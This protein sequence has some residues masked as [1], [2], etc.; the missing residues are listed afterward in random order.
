MPVLGRGLVCQLSVCLGMRALQARAWHDAGT[1]RPFNSATYSELCGNAGPYMAG[2]FG[3]VVVF[4]GMRSLT[5]VTVGC[6]DEK[7]VAAEV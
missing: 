7:A 3:L 1:T 2:C 4:C 5:L 6:S